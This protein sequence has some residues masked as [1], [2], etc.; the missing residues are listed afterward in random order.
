MTGFSVHLWSPTVMGWLSVTQ[1]KAKAVK[2]MSLLEHRPR[3]R[4]MLEQQRTFKLAQEL[5]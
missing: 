2:I 1:S 3:N 4:E 5:Q